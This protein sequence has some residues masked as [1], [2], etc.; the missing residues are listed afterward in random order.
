MILA[1]Y[2]VELNAM[3]GDLEREIREIADEPTLNVNSARQ[4]GEVLFAKLRITDKPKMT[5]T[6]QFSTDEEYLQ[7][8]AHSHRIVELILQYRGVKKLL[9]TYVEALPL[10]V[11]HSTGRI[12]TSFKP[13]AACRRPT[14]TCK[15]FQCAMSWVAVSARRLFQPTRSIYCFRPI[16]VRWS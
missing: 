13:Q 12:H 5:K 16:I 3:L 7:G 4:L 6:R 1:D 10:L 2:A 14:P 11:N 8:F 9:S 15:I